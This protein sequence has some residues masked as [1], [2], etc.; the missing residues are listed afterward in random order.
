MKDNSI[1]RHFPGNRKSILLIS[2][3][4]YYHSWIFWINWSTIWTDWEVL[5]AAPNNSPKVKASGFICVCL[6]SSKHFSKDG[7]AALSLN[8]TRIEF[9][10]QMSNSIRR[11][12]AILKIFIALLMS[13]SSLLVS[14]KTLN[15]LI[16]KLTDPSLISWT[17][18]T[19]KSLLPMAWKVCSKFLETPLHHTK[20]VRS[21]S[22][23]MSTGD[24]CFPEFLNNWKTSKDWSQ[25]RASLQVWT[26]ML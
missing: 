25:F 23:L 22:D 8:I 13:A 7:N 14:I 17:T 15:K 16:G 10:A 11:S 21:G 2:N 1:K 9:N 5:L 6:I 18:S 26:V 20:R 24:A 19:S 4:N 12:C 3:F